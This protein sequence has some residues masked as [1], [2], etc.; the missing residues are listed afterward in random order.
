M[1]PIPPFRRSLSH[2]NDCPAA[3]M[4]NRPWENAR[5]PPR[6]RTD[7]KDLRCTR[8]Q[9]R[10]RDRRSSVDVSRA[11]VGSAPIVC[12]GP[13]PLVA[14]P[15]HYRATT[16]CWRRP[17][18]SN[19]QVSFMRRQ[20]QR[21]AD[22]AASQVHTI[23]TL[24]EFFGKTHSHAWARGKPRARQKRR[25]GRWRTSKLAA[26]VTFREVCLWSVAAITCRTNG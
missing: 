9:F 19:K 3:S 20:I 10:R 23:Q 6:S 2:R 18:L 8:S 5:D 4:P 16:L 22:V 7:R 1:S 12:S 11:L 21:V 25:F 13:P 26:G 15:A 14:R 24:G 17:P